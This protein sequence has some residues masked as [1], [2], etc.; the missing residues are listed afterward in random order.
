V[1]TRSILLLT[2]MPGV[3]KTLVAGHI[4]HEW[5]LPLLSMSHAVRDEV[6]GRG[7]DPSPENYERV[8]EEIRASEGADAV[9]RR[10]I[11]ANGVNVER[12]LVVD[13]IRS[14]AEVEFFKSLAPGRALLVAIVAPRSVRHERVASQNASRVDRTWIE[15]LDWHNLRLG[16]GDCVALADVYISH[17][18]SPDL[19]GIVRAVEPSLDRTVAEG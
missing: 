15:R 16:V 12:G 11:R 4:R 13:G 5:N 9:A 7:D 18:G 17:V 19:A 2:G 8:A 1:N 10:S 14:P 3:R 6:I